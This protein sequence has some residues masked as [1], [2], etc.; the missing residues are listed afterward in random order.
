[1]EQCSD[2][3]PYA[4][5]AKPTP[6]LSINAVQSSH[7]AFFWDQGVSNVPA[8]RDMESSA[9]SAHL[10]RGV[11]ILAK[12]W[13]TLKISYKA[14]VDNAYSRCPEKELAHHVLLRLHCSAL[15]LL[16]RNDP[17][18]T[19]AL[20]QLSDEFTDKK[21]SGESNEEVA[22]EDHNAPSSVEQLR[23]VAFSG[24]SLSRDEL[25]QIFSFWPGREHAFN[26]EES[27]RA[28]TLGEGSHVHDSDFSDD[29]YD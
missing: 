8:S 6:T 22:A 29:L 27:P 12:L 11:D 19:E 20:K 17:T 3:L 26:H 25:Q 21:Q 13:P 16:L 9:P 24:P 18:L 28:D 2:A 10:K 1:M 5:A 7:V 4:A 14:I 15:D 23:D